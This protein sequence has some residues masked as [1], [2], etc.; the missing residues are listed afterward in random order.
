MNNLSEEQVCQL[1]MSP[2]CVLFLVASEYVSPEQISQRH[3]VRSVEYGLAWKM[4]FSEQICELLRSNL[5]EFYAN[6]PRELKGPFQDGLQDELLAVRQILEQGGGPREMIDDFKT[7]LIDFAFFVAGGGAF[8][9]QV[10]DMKMQ[11]QAAW[12]ADLFA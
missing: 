5:H 1:A 8:R 10:D 11:A 12:V 3:I 7:T 4:S 2:L 6:F 9:K